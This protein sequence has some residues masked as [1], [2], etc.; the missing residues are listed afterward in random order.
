MFPRAKCK[1]GARCSSNLSKYKPISLAPHQTRGR[2]G[3]KFGRRGREGPKFGW[4]L[5]A[6]GRKDPKVELFTF[7]SNA[8]S[9]K[10]PKVQYFTHV[11]NAGLALQETSGGEG[12]KSNRHGREGPKFGRCLNA[13]SRRDP[14]VELLTH[15]WL[16]K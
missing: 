2:E 1:M 6:G 10:D 5:N 16:H 7:A 8:G 9:R 3:P 14:K 13:G 4:R 12:P 15:V 11:S